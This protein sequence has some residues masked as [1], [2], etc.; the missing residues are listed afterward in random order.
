MHHSAMPAPPPAMVAPAIRAATAAD[1]PRLAALEDRAFSHDRISRRAFRYLLTRAN[2][3]V[4]AAT[5]GEALCGAA[6]LLFR[7]GSVRA[8]LYSIA[9]APE[10]QRAGTGAALLAAAE[11]EAAARGARF[12]RLEVRTDAALVQAFYRRR[13][14]RQTGLRRG[15]YQDGADAVCMQKA[16]ATAP[17]NAAAAPDRAAD[18]DG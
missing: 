9:V 14:F 18:G 12:L 6:V 7:T 17:D 3:V 2:A 13:G 15:Y 4:L 5:A 11:A 16:L 10:R 8:R 1:G